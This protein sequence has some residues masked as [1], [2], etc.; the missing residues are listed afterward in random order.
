MAA[1]FLNNLILFSPL[2]V[3]G[4][5][6][7]WFSENAGKLRSGAGLPTAP[8]RDGDQ[9]EAGA[10]AAELEAEEVEEE[11]EPLFEQEPRD[12]PERAPNR[13]L[14]NL[15]RVP[16]APPQD[17][18]TK[19]AKSRAKKDA[20]RAYH[21]HVRAAASAQREEWERVAPQWEAEME[22]ERERRRREE[23]RIVEQ[24]REERREKEEEWRRERERREGVRRGVEGVVQAG[25]MV[26][27]ADVAK[28]LH[29]T[30]EEVRAI[31]DEII[32]RNNAG[33]GGVKMMVTSTGWFVVLR[34]EDVEGMRKKLVAKGRISQEDIV[35]IAT[36]V[37]GTA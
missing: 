5:G 10:P 25:K 1:D 2:L 26:W 3:I 33:E 20:R 34:T 36:E 22:E 37:V 15:H 28:S 7:L 16:A 21:E 14:P 17:I 19:K 18:G 8:A 32:G 6:I 27:I 9:A 23:E 29:A 35:N 31:L 13:P 4:L 11:R 24:K 12:N 30:T